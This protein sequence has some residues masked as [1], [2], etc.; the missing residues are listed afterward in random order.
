MLEYISPNEIVMISESGTVEGQAF[1]ST[2]ARMNIKHFSLE[3]D[4]IKNDDLLFADINEQ[5]GEKLP[6]GTTVLKEAPAVRGLAIE[7]INGEK[8]LICES[9]LIMD[10]TVSKPGATP[11]AA[12]TNVSFKTIQ[13]LDLYLINLA[14]TANIHQV[15]TPARFVTLE[16]TSSYFSTLA[17]CEELEEANMFSYQGINEDGLFVRGFSQNHEFFNTIP[18]KATHDNILTRTY[19]GYP[20]DDAMPRQNFNQSF[21]K[22]NFV[23]ISAGKMNGFLNTNNGIV[24]YHFHSTTGYLQFTV[25]N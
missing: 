21:V 9:Y 12:A 19:W 10:K 6:D 25:L 11:Q 20:V 13:F 2:S 23:P 18:F 8:T 15:W 7:T 16:G 1:M 4:E 24:L 14:N 17:F 3:G 22:E 5:F